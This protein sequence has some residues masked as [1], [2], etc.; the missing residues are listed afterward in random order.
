MVLSSAMNGW[1]STKL[2]RYEDKVER[3]Y[4]S[5]QP[6]LISIRVQGRADTFSTKPLLPYTSSTRP[7]IF[8]IRTCPSN[9]I[10]ILS[11]LDPS[12][13]TLFPY[14]LNE[15][16]STMTTSRI[17]FMNSFD[18]PIRL[19][20][21]LFCLSLCWAGLVLSV[22]CVLP[23]LISIIFS[24]EP[25]G[26]TLFSYSLLTQFYTS[27]TSWIQPWHHPASHSWTYSIWPMRQFD[28]INPYLCIS[29]SDSYIHLIQTTLPLF[30]YKSSSTSPWAHELKLILFPFT[31]ASYF[32][33]IILNIRFE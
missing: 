21:T 17:P 9:L 11:R 24:S 30:S 7:A 28:L 2:S 13:Q 18:A 4:D 1:Q 31:T 27:S 6:N 33:N 22:H 16:N 3:T 5:F 19:N 25:V 10:F 29:S 26:Q 20:Q 23:N 8:S 14:Q 15:P 32:D 12:S